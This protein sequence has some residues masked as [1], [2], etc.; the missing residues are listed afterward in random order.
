MPTQQNHESKSDLLFVEDIEV[1]QGVLPVD[2][3]QP[4]Q[5]NPSAEDAAAVPH[6]A[7]GHV[8]G[9]ISGQISG[10]INDLCSVTL[11]DRLKQARRNRG[12]S[13]ADVAQT[14]NFQTTIVQSIESGDLKAL[15]MSYE[16]GFFR[17]YAI[18]VGED[19]LG[20]SIKDAVDAIRGD[21][22]PVA[23]LA[24]GIMIGHV[25]EVSRRGRWIKIAL[26]VFLTAGLIAWLAWPEGMARQTTT[27]GA[28]DV[29]IQYTFNFQADN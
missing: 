29:P 26:T 12:L 16:V 10:Q 7:D 2:V 20:V 19:G 6:L 9:Q 8:N 5:I 17:T 11:G 27:L 1:G 4:A 3:P 22:K 13:V 28:N 25:D 24:S 15:P 18:F 21:F 23:P 14:L